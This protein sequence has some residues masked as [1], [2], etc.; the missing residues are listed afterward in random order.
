MILFWGVFKRYIHNG[1]P[2]FLTIGISC[3][4][5]LGESSSGIRYHTNHM[6]PILQAFVPEESEVAVTYAFTALAKLCT[7]IFSN[8]FQERVYGI[9]S[10]H[11]L[12]FVGATRKVT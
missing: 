7:E 6:L 4:A 1:L 5:H 8:D 10:D 12:G 11:A 2:T 9:A 3:K